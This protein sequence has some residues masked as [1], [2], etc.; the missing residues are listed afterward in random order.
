ME[1]L[2]SPEIHQHLDEILGGFKDGAKDD[3]FL[4]Q[5]IVGDYNIKK[6]GGSNGLNTGLDFFMYFLN[7]FG[8][9]N[10]FAFKFKGDICYCTELTCSETIKQRKN[11]KRFK[12]HIFNSNESGI[13][14]AVIN[15]LCDHTRPG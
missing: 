15:K 9:N 6:I 8:I 4:R 12:A 3:K 14:N 11:P 5:K 1:N 2:P 13:K 7:K 10:L